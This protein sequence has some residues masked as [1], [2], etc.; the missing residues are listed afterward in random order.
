MRLLL[1]TLIRWLIA[2]S[3]LFAA[4]ACF[5]VPTNANAPLLRVNLS[6]AAVLIAAMT[7]FSA[8]LLEGHSRSHIAFIGAVVTSIGFCAYCGV[9]GGLDSRL[10][11]TNLA[12]TIIII[13]TL[14]FA[15]FHV[16]AQTDRLLNLMNCW[17]DP[18]GVKNWMTDLDSPDLVKKTFAIQTMADYL[19]RGY[20]GLA[21]AGEL[22]S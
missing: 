19:G 12:A 6:A 10:E 20:H 3:L 7:V 18:D 13:L 22:G 16:I 1:D 15:V 9:Q 11:P 2:V 21:S 14:W 17:L 8:F 4:G 5:T